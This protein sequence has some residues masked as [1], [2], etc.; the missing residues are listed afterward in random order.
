MNKNAYLADFGIA[1]QL[2]GHANGHEDQEGTLIGSPAYLSP[3]QIRSE[4][5]KPQTD[6]YSLGLLIYE[7][8]TGVR[9]FQGPTPVAYLQQHLN[10]MPPSILEHNQDLPPELDL[11]LARAMAKDPALRFESVIEML[12]ELDRVMLPLTAQS[13]QVELSP[14][15]VDMTTQA[16][17]EV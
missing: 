17:A 16:L 6:I 1:K 13:F 11:L 9:P 15:L 7:M 3:E 12:S 2:N 8:L 5:I 10:E 4:P 14:E